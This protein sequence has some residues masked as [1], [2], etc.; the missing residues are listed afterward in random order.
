MVSFQ[1][2][3]CVYHYHLG[4]E[5]IQTGNDS[6]LPAVGDFSLNVTFNKTLSLDF[7]ETILIR[8]AFRRYQKSELLRKRMQTLE[9]IKEK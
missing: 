7:T 6:G 5:N 8:T 3:F 4:T 2:R 1:L 9:I